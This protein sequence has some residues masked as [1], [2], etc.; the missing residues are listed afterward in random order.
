MTRDEALDALVVHL[1]SEVGAVVRE[2]RKAQEI[3]AIAQLFGALHLAQGN[4][5][6]AEEFLHRFTT[7]LGPVIYPSLDLA[8]SPTR[9]LVLVHECA[10]V[11]QFYD[12][13]LIFPARYLAEKEYRAGKE[14][15]AIH[16]Q[17]EVSHWLTGKLP[18]KLTD[19][20]RGLTYGYALTEQDLLFAQRFL[21]VGATMISH[22]VYTTP[23]GVIATKW[24]NEHVPELYHACA[25]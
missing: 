24:L 8:S 23:V 3:Q 2:K 12:S 4:L 14:A 1:C 11:V 17:L 18:G 16:S 21:E 5:P 25:Y 9:H 6:D 10:H 7:T 20:P 22:S 13:P 15:N 19:L